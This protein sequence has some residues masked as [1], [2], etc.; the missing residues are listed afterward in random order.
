MINVVLESPYYDEQQEIGKFDWVQLTYA[1]L[2]A[3]INGDD[4]QDVARIT[5]TNDWYLTKQ[6][7]REHGFREGPWSDII[8]G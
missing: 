3:S 8:I 5:A 6:Y 7:A 1:T 2:R 4:E